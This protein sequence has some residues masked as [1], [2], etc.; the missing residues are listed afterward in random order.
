[1]TSS[2]GPDHLANEDIASLEAKSSG[3]T[4]FAKAGYIRIQQD[5]CNKV[6]RQDSE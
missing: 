2:A 6:D 1:M 4:L 3:S 5:Q